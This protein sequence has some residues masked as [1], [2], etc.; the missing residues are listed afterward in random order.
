MKRDAKSEAQLVESAKAAQKHA[1]A[2][3]SHF[4]V[5][6]AV[7]TKG[8]RIFSGCNVE[9]VAFPVGTCAEQNAIGAMVTAGFQRI[10][11]IVIVGP[12]ET[13]LV[14][15]GACRQRILEFSHDETLIL[16]ANHAEIKTVYTCEDLLPHG[17]KPDTL[18]QK[19]T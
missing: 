15:C 9:N 17:F 13:A 18:G 10:E 16:C 4:P 11:A 7:L 2:P 3:H 5:G 14:P 19:G 6:A 1:Y 12:D 8:G